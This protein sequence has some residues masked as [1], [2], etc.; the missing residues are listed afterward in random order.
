MVQDE[1]FCSIG[2]KNVWQNF[3]VSL[4]NDVSRYVIELPATTAL[5]AVQ[6]LRRGKCRARIIPT[7]RHCS[8]LGNGFTTERPSFFSFTIMLDPNYYWPWQSTT[9]CVKLRTNEKRQIDTVS[10]QHCVLQWY[11]DADVHVPLN[12]ARMPIYTYA[13]ESQVTFTSCLLRISVS[14]CVVHEAMHR[15][16]Y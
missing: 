3:D 9:N 7:V 1:G 5:V 4:S 2:S 13:S 16:T 6:K 8:L 14:W 10:R 12:H 11:T 15:P